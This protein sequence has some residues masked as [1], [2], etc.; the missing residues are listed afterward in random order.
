MGKIFV[1]SMGVNYDGTYKESAI[2]DQRLATSISVTYIAVRDPGLKGASEVWVQLLR[3]VWNYKSVYDKLAITD[4]AL[5]HFYYP[6]FYHHPNVTSSLAP[7][8]PSL[9]ECYVISILHLATVTRVL[10]HFY[11]PS[12]HR[13]PSVR[14]SLY[15]ICHCNQSV[16]SSLACILPS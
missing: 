11:D 10:G 9:T 1:S 12:S 7:N 4:R 2:V 16:R 8:L 3:S 6:S 15:Q 14:S 13:N 5:G